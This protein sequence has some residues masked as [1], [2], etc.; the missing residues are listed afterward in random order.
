MT[1]EVDDFFL[2]LLSGGGAAGPQQVF[3]ALFS[4]RDSA[5]SFFLATLRTFPS[6]AERLESPGLARAAQRALDDELLSILATGSGLRGR[7]IFGL[8][9]FFFAGFAEASLAAEA[10]PRRD[11]SNPLVAGLQAFA[12]SHRR[13]DDDLT[14]PHVLVAAWVELLGGVH[15]PAELPADVGFLALQTALYNSFAASA[16]DPTKRL[17]M[18]LAATL[19]PSPLVAAILSKGSSRQATESLLQTILVRRRVMRG[20]SFAYHFANF[21]FGTKGLKKALRAAT[22]ALPAD[23]ASLLQERLAP[24]VDCT[25]PLSMRARLYALM[26]VA[27]EAR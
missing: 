10:E 18:R 17:A 22:A 20:R 25:P 11:A 7:A 2:P 19:V 13:A 3:H 14:D 23:E 9:T 16:Q 8:T 26:G 21:G 12:A 15:S 5:L 4:R 6:V 1:R 24:I 27:D